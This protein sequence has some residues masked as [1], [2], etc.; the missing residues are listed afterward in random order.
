M[1]RRCVARRSLSWR[2]RRANQQHRHR[3]GS[4]DLL[5]VAAD[6]EAPDTAPTVRA[7][8]DEVGVPE[9]GLGVDDVADSGAEGLGQAGV[10]RDAARLDPR[11]RLRQDLRAG[12]Q[13]DAEDVAVASSRP[14][15]KIRPSTT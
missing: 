13:Q 11:L 12:V 3:G 9:L 4:D 8:H 15:E 6:E 14:A 10:D 5:R 2:F 1:V 7:D